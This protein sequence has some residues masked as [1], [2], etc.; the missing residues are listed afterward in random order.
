MDYLSVIKDIKNGDI[1]SIYFL[2]GEEPFYIDKITQALEQVLLE[3][4]KAF[5]QTILYGND[6]KMDQ[7]ISY[8][9][10]F[11]MSGE[12]TMVIVREAQSFSKKDW[13]QLVDYAENPQKSTILAFAYKGKKIDKRSKL[14]KV[15]A[16]KHLLFEGK[17]LYD[18]QIPEY[19][20]RIFKTEGLAVEAQAKFLLVECI[21]SDLSRLENEANKL[22]QVVG[23]DA[24]VTADLV[25]Y[26]VGISKSFN[27]FEL[28]KAVGKKDSKKA[29]QIVDYFSADPNNHPVVLSISLLYN[30]FSNLLKYQ[31]LTDKSKMNVAKSL[32]VNPYFVGDYVLAAQNY[33][34]KKVTYA[35]SQL[36]DLDLKSKGV[37][38]ESKT[39]SEL[40]KE[41]LQKVLYN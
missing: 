11:P 25:E 1:Q 17:R 32:K 13:D 10:Q 36:R 15:L 37:N 41:F 38:N 8:A 31:V 33:S 39:H 20:E 34:I 26:H 4:E 40:L 24:L 22:A 18:N 12:Y 23:E 7:V 35:I 5:N 30:L 9:K 21:G 28:I 29:F 16:K 3:E 14:A 6:V 2:S 27:N 19:I